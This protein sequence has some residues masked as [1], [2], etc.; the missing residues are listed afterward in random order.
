M[1]DGAHCSDP[2]ADRPGYGARCRAQAA[3]ARAMA[4]RE[5]ALA[6]QLAVFTGKGLDTVAMVERSLRAAAG[7][8]QLGAVHTAQALAY[9]DMIAAGGPDDS[10]AYVEYEAMTRRHAALYPGEGSFGN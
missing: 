7:L 3:L 9:D 2:G 4:E 5:R 1:T 8:K 6:A 10:R